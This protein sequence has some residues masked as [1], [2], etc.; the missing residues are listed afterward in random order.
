[1]LQGEESTGSR[2]E[3]QVEIAVVGIGSLTPGETS[4]R[5]FWRSV[6]DGD[7][8]I[9]DVPSSH[10]N[11]ED[12]YDPDPTAQIGFGR[13]QP[14][15]NRSA[16]VFLQKCPRSFP[17]STRSSKVITFRSIFFRI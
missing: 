8:L 2:D 12:Y 16:L 10:W 14:R 15:S 7:D 3:R 4:S 11:I 9:T 17:K 13:G 6:I 1:M 5:S